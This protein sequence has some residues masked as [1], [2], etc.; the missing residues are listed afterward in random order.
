MCFSAK[1]PPPPAAPPPPPTARD[2]QLEGT[3]DR[4]ARARSAAAYGGG[5]SSSGMGGDASLAPTLK[6]TLGA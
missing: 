2:A 5:A 6:P 3:R 1:A 4:S